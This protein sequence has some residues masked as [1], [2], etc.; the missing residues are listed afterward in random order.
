MRHLLNILFALV[1]LSL[2]SCHSS[3]KDEANAEVNGNK[4]VVLSLDFDASSGKT[5]LTRN[6][7]HNESHAAKDV[8]KRVG[9]FIFESSTG[10]KV[11]ED[12]TLT[13]K[14]QVRL[15]PGKYDLYILGN[16]TDDMPRYQMNREELNEYLRELKSI[17]AFSTNSEKIPM[18]RIYENQT[19]DFET[20]PHP[21]QKFV[22]QPPLHHPL[23]P[24]S[25][26]GSDGDNAQDINVVRS[27][28]NVAIKLYG[29]GAKQVSSIS[30]ENASANYTLVELDR[31]N[32]PEQANID[33][34]FELVRNGLSLSVVPQYI[35]ECIF[36]DT[37]DKGWIKSD[38][39]GIDAPTGRVN[40]LLIR[41]ISGTEY[42]IPIVSN[43]E[44]A[45]SNYLEFARNGLNANYDIIRN[46]SYDFSIK[47]PLDHREL[48]VELS[49]QPWNKVE[50]EMSYTKP[51]VNVQRLTGTGNNQNIDMDRNE[52]I[53][54]KLSI[55]KGNGQDW[56]MALS[57]G[58]DFVLQAEDPTEEGELGAYRGIVEG[59]KTYVFG[60]KPLKPYEGTPRFTEL[61]L[62]V[63]GN[64]VPLFDGMET[65]PGNRT[66]IKQ[67]EIR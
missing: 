6:S 65:G 43:P 14:H 50:S 13:L 23:Y 28:A 21:I 33:I 15:S 12:H 34:P 45:E 11:I 32:L 67:T 63:N 35:P 39:G 36:S 24:V 37:E 62:L 18:V 30:Y 46:Y 7:A 8:L 17:K 48:N 16:P 19:I 44:D 66:V 49:V 38:E 64:E 40:Y 29:D 42:K 54:F 59:N 1:S 52:V 27:L 22:P 10:K 55:Q 2:L 26:Y 60:V 41:M 47:V 25:S 9:L 61:Y 51:L 56:K 4:K 5:T 3:L 31:N 53:K 58:L 57:N 20:Y